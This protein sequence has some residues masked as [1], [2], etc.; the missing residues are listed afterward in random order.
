VASLFVFLP[1]N[2]RAHQKEGNMKLRVALVGI[3]LGGGAPVGAWADEQQPNCNLSSSL[4]NHI[5]AQLQAVVNLPDANG[6]IFKPNRMWSAVVDRQGTLCSVINT[7]A[8][9]GDAWPGSRAIAIAKAATANDFSNSALAL[10]T[11][12]LYAPTQPGGSLYVEQLQSLQPAIPA[13]W[14]GY[15]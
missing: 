13:N 15:Q 6:G 8:T 7:N 5:Q 10:S 12:N 1:V 14:Y 2:L 11:A 3:I 4:V 9:S